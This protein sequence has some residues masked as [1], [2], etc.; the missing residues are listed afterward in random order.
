MFGEQTNRL[1]D[2]RAFTGPNL[3]FVVDKNLDDAPLFE[4][5]DFKG[6]VWGWNVGLGFDLTIIFVDVGYTFGLSEVFDNLDSSARNNLFYA[7]AGLRIG[8]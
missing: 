2:I 8:F 7:N 1:F 5:D 6:S 3:S 4:S